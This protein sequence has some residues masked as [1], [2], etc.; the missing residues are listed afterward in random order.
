M[1]KVILFSIVLLSS[2]HLLAQTNLIEL[3]PSEEYDNIKV[4]KLFSDERSTSFV[5]WVKDNVKAHKHE[6]H[7]ESL[8]VI[9]GT[10][11]M[12][13]GSDTINIKSGDFITIPQ[14]TVHQVKVTSSVPLK[15]ISVQAPEF[16]GKDRIFIEDQTNQDY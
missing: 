13:L 14:N 15:V 6:H 5:I 11:V 12:V 7:T 16:F 3:A 8:Y 4:E 1:K 10:G 9:E 2:F